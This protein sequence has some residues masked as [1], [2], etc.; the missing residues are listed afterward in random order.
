MSKRR[1]P[2]GIAQPK[3]VSKETRPR[4]L[5]S[6]YDE[7]TGFLLTPVLI[8]RYARPIIGWSKEAH[9]CMPL[10]LRDHGY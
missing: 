10:Y 6:C 3:C 8:R 9:R 5:C 2:T 4:V 7:R 1:L